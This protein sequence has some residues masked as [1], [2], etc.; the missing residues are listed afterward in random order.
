MTATDVGAELL[1][2]PLLEKRPGA[3]AEIAGEMGRPVGVE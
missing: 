3:L 2:D 1:M